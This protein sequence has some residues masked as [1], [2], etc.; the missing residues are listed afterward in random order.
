MYISPHPDCTCVSL[1]SIHVFLFVTATSVS[2]GCISLSYDCHVCQ[3]SLWSPALHWHWHFTQTQDYNFS[4]LPLS[5]H[6]SPGSAWVRFSNSA[7]MS[8]QTREFL[9][10]QLHDVECKFQRACHE[11]FVLNIKIRDLQTRY[12]R[13]QKVGRKSF[14]YTLRIHLATTEGTRNMYYENACRKA[15]ELDKIHDQLA[16][17]RVARY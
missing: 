4:P 15:D 2:N 1:W 17:W 3:V 7:T 12:D 10:D 6:F 9:T 14:R 13:A 8:E 5:L 11:V 16:V